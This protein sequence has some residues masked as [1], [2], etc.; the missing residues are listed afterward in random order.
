[1][2]GRRAAALLLV[3]VALAVRPAAQSGSPSRFPLRVSAD[4]RHLDDAS[5]KPF[6]VVG[7]AAWSLIAQLDD[8]STTA[9]LEDRARRGFTAIIVSLIE[10]KF[11]THAPA[12]HAGMSPFLETGNFR[13]PNPAYFES[14]HRVVAEAGAH[15]L[16]VW[17]CPAYLGWQ[18]GDE[19]FFKEIKKAGPQALYSYGKFVGERFRDLPNVVWM[20]GG[21][22][23]L[24]P[25][26]RWAGEQL[27]WGL[28]DGGAEQIVTAHGGQTSAVETYGN[29]RWLSLDTV[30]SYEADLRPALLRAREGRPARPFVLIETIYE[31]EHDA[32]PDQIRRQAWQAM[33]SGAAGQFFG[34]NPIWHFDGPTLF[35]FSGDWKQALDS[36]GSRDMARLAAFFS[37]REWWTLEPRARAGAA[38]TMAS[39]PGGRAVVYVAGNGSKD[40][41]DITLPI[42]APGPSAQ[43]FNPAR[44][45]PMR[46]IESAGATGGGTQVRT[47]GDNG[48]GTNDWVIVD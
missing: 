16:S 14:A 17:L 3:V 36:T 25:Q 26:D 12:N 44:D 32:T 41:Q 33:L 22:D 27:V 35:P 13:K 7:D 8:T 37:A 43:W 1:M 29:T 39:A 38:I 28:R 48:T 10:H 45:E 42:P 9:Y 4:Q 34:N 47:P 2:R 20:V 19:G 6:L 21:D 18:G 5:G 15:G 11:A 46:P 31:S 24:A 23:A 30:Y 40:A